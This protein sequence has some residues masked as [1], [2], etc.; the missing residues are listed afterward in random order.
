MK[1]LHNIWKMELI[2]MLISK[3]KYSALG[4]LCVL[5]FTNT[6][7]ASS[8]YFWSESVPMPSCTGSWD[9]TVSER[10]SSE[11]SSEGGSMFTIMVDG[12]KIEQDIPTCAEAKKNRVLVVVNG[13]YLHVSATVEGWPYIE[14]G[15][16]MAPMRAIADV[17]GF[18]VDWKASEQKI[19][20]TKEEKSI[21]MHIGK[22]E[23][24]VDGKKV[25]LEDTVPAIKKGVTFLPIRQL[26]EIL[27]IDVEWDSKTR[28]ARFTE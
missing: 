7:Y 1:Y 17:F 4:L 13:L 8:D 2:Q 16:T 21:V 22:S 23:M 5:V 14:N 15:R 26:A 10:A 11:G 3:L 27:G 24:L 6:A 28:T 20:L 25:L 19:T 9:G 18:E 12:K